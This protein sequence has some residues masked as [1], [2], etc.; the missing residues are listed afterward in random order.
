MRLAKQFLDVG[1]LT[2]QLEPMLEFWQGV[3][4]LPFEEALPTGGGTVQHRHG[5]NGAVLKVNHS[6]EVLPESAPSGYRE[7]LVAKVGLAEPKPLADPDGNRVT[8]VP[9][10]HRGVVAAG[11]VI[12]V[13]D[14]EAARRYYRDALGM[15]EVDVGVLRLGESLIFLVGH[16]PT[17]PHGRA[18]DTSVAAQ[19]GSPGASGRRG[20]GYRYL[21]AQV[22]DADAECAGIAER[23][24]TLAMAPR[25]MGSVARFGFVRDP[26]GNMLEISQRASLTGPLPQD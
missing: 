16:E 6:R 21:T 23:G 15:E 20:K 11:V 19:D 13:S 12:A 5:L 8:L 3:V 7:L 18:T 9:V 22:W 10:G 2:N 1:L 17:L 14:M 24:G 25:T 4:G 26:D